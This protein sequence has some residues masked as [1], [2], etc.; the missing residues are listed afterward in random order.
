MIATACAALCLIG[1]GIWYLV[2]AHNHAV[3][4]FDP[5]FAVPL[6][7]ILFLFVP[8]Y[9]LGA[10]LVGKHFGER[11]G[12]L[13]GWG[14]EQPRKTAERTRTTIAGL[15]GW[16]LM[17]LAIVAVGSLALR[18]VS[19]AV[20]DWERS[21]MGPLQRAAC[22]G[23]VSRCEQL[24]KSGLSVDTTDDDGVTAL[25]WAIFC[26]K[27][28]VVRK[29]ID[30]GADVNHV[31]RRGEFTPLMYTASSLRGH[32]LRGTQEQRNEIAQVLIEH[33]ADVNR[34]MDGGQTVLHFAVVDK[35]LKLVRT[36]LK[37]GANPNAKSKQGYT[38]LDVARFPD[39]APND[40][41]IK[42]LE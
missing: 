8:V 5:L 31:D 37:A 13:T 16:L 27:G 10:L 21:K 2:A 11:V 30:L 40:E 32:F 6:A 4:G 17:A 39:Y 14:R 29:L 15:L 20:G 7:V 26:C 35:N 33:G 24:V 28:D 23:E 12:L 41:I 22:D 9:L 42:A 25:D 36:L 34:T 38:P 19:S 3:K 1:C 18:G